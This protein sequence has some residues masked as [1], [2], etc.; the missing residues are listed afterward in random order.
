MRTATDTNPTISPALRN[1]IAAL[2]PLN[3]QVV[4]AIIAYGPIKVVDLVKLVGKTNQTIYNA[5]A[6]S[7]VALVNVATIESTA[8][9]YE[10]KA[11][12]TPLPVVVPV[13]APV[14]APVAAPAPKLALAVEPA[15]D[16][17]VEPPP[18][19]SLAPVRRIFLL[20]WGGFV[21]LDTIIGIQPE[22]G[23]VVIQQRGGGF[24]RS[25]SRVDAEAIVD[26]IASTVVAFDDVQT[27]SVGGGK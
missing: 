15:L 10:L 4:N 1:A 21:M 9:R 12:V 18:P 19:R 6:S 20:P 16:P 8:S 13:L 7:K 5:I 14:L 11:R 2:S 26:A 17:V 24:M 27:F 22:R 23:S 25:P 3:R